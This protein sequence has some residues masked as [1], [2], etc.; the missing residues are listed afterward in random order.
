MK[1]NGLYFQFLTLL[2]ALFEITSEEL[3]ESIIRMGKT[4]VR[5]RLIID[6]EYMMVTGTKVHKLT[7]NGCDFIHDHTTG[8]FHHKFCVID[9]E[10]VAT[11]SLNWTRQAVI[12]NYEN[13]LIVKHK[14]C[15]GK[16]SSSLSLSLLPYLEVALK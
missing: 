14:E 2:L 7:E 3:S 16:F 4:G 9:G 15:I 13:V 5:V 10:V 8:L 1:S 11:G 6:S 12:G